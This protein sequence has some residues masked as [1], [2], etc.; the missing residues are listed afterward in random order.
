METVR[1]FIIICLYVGNFYSPHPLSYSVTAA[2]T[3]LPA[4][5]YLVH[6]DLQSTND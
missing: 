6:L 4:I 5:L 2:S 1:Q 3:V